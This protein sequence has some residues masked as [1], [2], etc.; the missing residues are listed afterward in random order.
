MQRPIPTGM[1]MES[2]GEDVPRRILEEIR[3]TET[4]IWIIRSYLKSSSLHP[5]GSTSEKNKRLRQQNTGQR[6]LLPI[7]AFRQPPIMYLV[8]KDHDVF[9]NPI[10]SSYGYWRVISSRI[11]YIR[12]HILKAEFKHG[13]YN[14]VCLP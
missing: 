11:R 6:T 4:K 1:S 7:H 10:K 13:V 14:I 2:V 9:S 12:I 3:G 5:K 8:G